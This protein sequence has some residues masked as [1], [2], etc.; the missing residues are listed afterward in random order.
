M[1]HPPRET[2]K[3]NGERVHW[4]IERSSREGGGTAKE[5]KKISAIRREM[6]RGAI[7]KP[8]EE[9]VSRKAEEAKKG[10]NISVNE[11]DNSEVVTIPREVE[12]TLEILMV[13][14]RW[15]GRVGRF[16]YLFKEFGCKSGAQ[17]KGNSGE[18]GWKH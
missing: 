12:I 1:K 10:E 18:S 8:R 6:R 13:T 16:P 2:Q 5:T 17:G 14:E 4:D 3:L 9:N 7:T 11:F 15:K